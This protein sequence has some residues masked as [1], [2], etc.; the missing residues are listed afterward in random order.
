MKKKHRNT[1]LFLPLTVEIPIW[2]LPDCS[3]GRKSSNGKGSAATWLDMRHSASVCLVLVLTILFVKAVLRSCYLFVRALLKG[4]YPL[5]KAF[6]RDSY[7]LS[8][9]GA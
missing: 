2:G 8:R 3:R 6:V 1:P 9:V 4:S 5:F 7:P